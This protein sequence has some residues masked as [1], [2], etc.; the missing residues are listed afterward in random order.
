MAQDVKYN[1]MEGTDF[2]K[3]K[4]YK[5]VQVPKSKL[6]EALLTLVVHGERCCPLHSPTAKTSDQML[7]RP[8]SVSELWRDPCP[9]RGVMSLSLIN[10]RPA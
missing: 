5:W 2:S 6:I 4:T 10:R 7:R 3:Y 8:I 9:N 1:F